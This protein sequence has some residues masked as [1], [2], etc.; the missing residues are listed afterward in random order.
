MTTAT[1]GTSSNVADWA[2]RSDWPEP[3]P[4]VATW[5]PFVDEL[6]DRAVDLCELAGLD[7]DEWQ[8]A[9]LRIALGKRPDGSGLWAHRLVGAEVPR[10]DGKGVILEGRQ[11]AGMF[12]IPDEL[13]IIHTAHEFKTATESFTRLAALVEDEP[14]LSR[15]VETIYTANGKEAIILK[16]TDEH[17]R[18]RVKFLARSKKSGRGF[19]SDL[20]IFDEAQELSAEMVG[21]AGPTQSARPNPQT[22]YTG[23]AGDQHADVWANVRDSG[24]QG[25]PRQAWI[26]Y[27]AGD[28]DDHVGDSIDLDDRREWY[29]ANPAMH[30]PSPR[31]TEEAV[32]NDRAMMDDENFARERLCL[33]WVER[34]VSIIDADVWADLIKPGCEVGDK[35]C[36]A[37]DVPP[38]RDSA[39]IAVAS[40]LADG[41][42]HAELV[43]HRPGTSWVVE[44]IV[45]L[46][47]KWSP[48]HIA[49]QPTSP[50]GSLMTEI[51]DAL[52]EKRVPVLPVSG[53]H[54]S[55]AC[56]AFLDLVNDGRLDVQ[57]NH[58]AEMAAAVDAARKRE[59]TDGG[60]VWNRRD[61]SS[62]IAPL[63]ALTLATH[64]VG[65]EPKRRRKKRTTNP[66]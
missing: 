5:D 24:I 62:N 41:R 19:T 54:L 60:F 34:R 9:S 23:T 58:T 28:P 25:T 4:R 47:E 65:V 45:E 22:I 61:A 1:L 40:E 46:D 39:S 53:V 49:I 37:V 14:L 38:E 35:V 33:W 31:M 59:L 44:R 16:P 66:F 50:A 13:L 51:A 12:L 27:A 42:R 17:P 10:Q 6:G 32:E 55:Q 36:F 18:K 11:L 3:R 7:L 26:E 63:M 57:Q 30:G 8:D 64:A 21:A 29:R 15:E 52:S 20:L 56:G 43:D 2:G 48:Q